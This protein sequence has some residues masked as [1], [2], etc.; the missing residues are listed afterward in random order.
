MTITFLDC[1]IVIV[2]FSAVDP[3]VMEVYS[4][5]YRD[6]GCLLF[7]NVIFAYS[8]HAGY[9]GKSEGQCHQCL[10]FTHVSGPENE[11]SILLLFKFIYLFIG[12]GLVVFISVA[13]ILNF[14]P[15]HLFVTSFRRNSPSSIPIKA[16]K[17][18]GKGF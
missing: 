6:F 16:M 18:E 5:K 14:W 12:L 3:I 8:A 11:K 15:H 4:N 17:Y 9:A 10:Y 2:H 13:A 7:F 1:E